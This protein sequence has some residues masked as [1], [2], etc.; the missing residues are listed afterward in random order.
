MER[1]QAFAVELGVADRDHASV[2]VDIA[3]AQGDRLADAHARGRQQ[4]EQRLVGGCPQPGAQRAGLAQQAADLLLRPQVGCGAM[5]SG[6]KHAGGRH[7]GGGIDGF[8]VA[9][10]AAGDGQALCPVVGGGVL[11]QASPGDGELSGDRRGAAGL[12]VADQLRE[13]LAGAL[14]LVAQRAAHRQVIAHVTGQRAH[15]WALPGH[16]AASSRSRSRST[17]A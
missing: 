16:G 5:P 14:E 6:G 4:A 13:Q 17:R 11:G 12:Q 7:L 3:A 2:Q 8:Q 10:E 1:H 9:G 15:R